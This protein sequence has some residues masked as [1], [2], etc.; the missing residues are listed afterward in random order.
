LSLTYPDQRRLKALAGKAFACYGAVHL[1]F[2]NA[3]VATGETL[4]ES[5]V[6]DW[7]WVLGVNL[8]GVI[9]G[10]RSF[11]PRLL[12]QNVESHIINTALI[13]GLITSSTFGTYVVSKHGIVAFSESLA[14][15]LAQLNAPIKVSLLCPHAV[16]TPIAATTE[17]HHPSALQNQRGRSE[18]AT[19]AFAALEAM[20]RAGKSPTEIAEITFTALGEE[21]F[22]IITHEE[23]IPAVRLRANDLITGYAPTPLD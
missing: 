17:R 9:N 5:T 13:A 18:V 11:V 16:D 21:R 23:T 6:E 8:G 2:N 22:R 14:L 12:K 19:K 3:G 7:T 10:T 20:T 15:Q 4:W 1:L